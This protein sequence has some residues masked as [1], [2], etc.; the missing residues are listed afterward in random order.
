M[1]KTRLVFKPWLEKLLTGILIF[2]FV[3]LVSINDCSSLLGLITIY[4]ILVGSSV[5]IAKLLSTYGRNFKKDF[6][7]ED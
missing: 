3:F 1:K 7:V 6:V 5:V 2:N 4:A